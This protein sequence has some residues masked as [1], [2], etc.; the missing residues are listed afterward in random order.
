MRWAL[1]DWDRIPLNP[2]VFGEWKFRNAEAD[3]FETKLLLG[4]D[5][6][7]RWHG[8]MNIFFE[9]QVGD[10]REQE[11][12]G[13]GALSYTL[14]DELLSVG[15]EMEFT[16]EREAAP[17]PDESND[18]KYKFV[19]GPSLQ[20]R[21]F[22]HFFVDVVPLFGTTDDSP[23]IESF[24]VIGFDFNAPSESEGIEPPVSV[25]TK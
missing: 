25:R 6:V 9:Q 11:I 13:T 1:A 10:Q 7:P 20:W 3:S 14:L 2:T 12:A 24:I 8:G 18:F 15:I 22:S 5:I 19:I 4:G 17:P 16:A 23:I 21:P